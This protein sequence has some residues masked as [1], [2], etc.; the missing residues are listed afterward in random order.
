MEISF[1][2]E[3]LKK[4][5]LARPVGTSTTPTVVLNALHVLYNAMR[6]ADNL[7]ELP[8]G[9]PDLTALIDSIEWTIELVDHFQVR[10][11]INDLNPLGRDGMKN[12]GRVRRVQVIA[13]EGPN[14]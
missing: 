13:I 11:R 4:A 1:A 14:G 3:E 12:L 10:L 5:C 8:F 6:N 2:T 9:Q 7:E